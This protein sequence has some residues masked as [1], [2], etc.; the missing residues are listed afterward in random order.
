MSTEHGTHTEIEL[1]DGAVLDTLARAPSLPWLNARLAAMP[2]AAA[3]ADETL[4]L[5]AVNPAC[6]AVLE[7][8]SAALLGARTA[9]LLGLEAL[10]RD[11]ELRQLPLAPGVSRTVPARVR[12]LDGSTSELTLTIARLE[13]PS[14]RALHLVT[15]QTHA[16][17][18]R[19]A[20][21]RQP[22]CAA[23]CPR[24]CATT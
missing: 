15:L 21:A 22:S 14:E 7:R 19:P 11:F 23:R 5:L 9:S 24:R 2:A 4:C 1:T 8:S 10:E 13:L 20:A 17:R 18:H 12:R 16:R 6:C 3:I